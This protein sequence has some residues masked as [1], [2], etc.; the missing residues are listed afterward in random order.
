MTVKCVEQSSFKQVKYLERG[1]IG[2]GD[3]VAAARVK[4]QAV[5]SRCVSWHPQRQT[6]QH[7]KLCY[8]S[9]LFSSKHTTRLSQQW[10]RRDDRNVPWSCHETSR[11][12]HRR[13]GIFCHQN[14]SWTEID[15]IIQ[16]KTQHSSVVSALLMELR[17]PLFNF[18]IKYRSN[19]RWR[20]I[21]AVVIVTV[22]WSRWSLTFD[23]ARRAPTDCVHSDT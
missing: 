19:S 13:L 6:S 5:H 15:S 8:N 4:W 3:K 12:L 11:L 14:S 21:N 2:R 23:T 7:S 22:K 9:L 17:T 1:I 10:S 18:L 20:A 16:T